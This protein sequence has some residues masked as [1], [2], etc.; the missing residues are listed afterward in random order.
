MQSETIALGPQENMS[1]IN[2][3]KNREALDLTFY[4]SLGLPQYAY[5]PIEQKYAKDFQNLIVC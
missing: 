2:R 4:Y 5:K 1:K 3:R